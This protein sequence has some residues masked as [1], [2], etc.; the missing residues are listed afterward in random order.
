MLPLLVGVSGPILALTNH[1]DG[2][3]SLSKRA[4]TLVEAGEE[5]VL[6]GYVEQILGGVHRAIQIG[7]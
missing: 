5:M 1:P 7:Q 4:L 2:F 6:A 3:L